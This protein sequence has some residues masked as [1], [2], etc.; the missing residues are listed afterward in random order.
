MT[1]NGK[2]VLS[3]TAPSLS[4][5]RTGAAPNLAVLISPGRIP[6]PVTAAMSAFPVYPAKGRIA[7]LVGN[8]SI[9]QAIEAPVDPVTGSIG[10]NPQQVAVHIAPDSIA[11]CIR[12]ASEHVALT[13]TT[14]G[15]TKCI[16]VAMRLG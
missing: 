16:G 6:E 1:W 14:D 15:I 11:R 3:L 12:P 13:V 8:T 5:S 9:K 2:K 10:C 4:F 7:K